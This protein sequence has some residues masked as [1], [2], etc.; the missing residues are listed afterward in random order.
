MLKLAVGQSAGTDGLKVTRAA[1]A[2]CLA[3]L[4]DTR[5]QAVLA[6]AAGEFDLAQV[7]AT[8]RAQWPGMVLVGCTSAGDFSSERGFDEDS[9]LLLCLGGDDLV[10][11]AGVVRELSLIAPQELEP[12]LRAALAQARLPAAPPESLCLLFPAGLSHGLEEVLATFQ[13]LLAPG[14]AVFGGLSGLPASSDPTGSKQLFGEEALRDGMPFLLL[15]G[16]SGPIDYGFSVSNSWTPVGARQTITSADGYVIHRIGERAALDFY[17][18]YLGSHTLPSPEFPLAVFQPDGENYALHVPLKADL[19]TG[20]ITYTSLIPEGSV[21]Q[22]TE[23]VRTR[24][25]DQLPS[26][27]AHANAQ[28]TTKPAVALAFSCMTRRQLLASQTSQEVQLLKQQLP[29]HVPLFG[30][31]ALGEIAPLVRKGPSLLHASSLVTLLLGSPEDVAA[32]PSSSSPLP[33]TAAPKEQPAVR[34]LFRATPSGYEELLSAAQAM[35][36]ELLA[37]RLARAE[38]ALQRMEAS[39]DNSSTLLRT[40]NREIDAA[41][42]L[43]EEQ[44]AVLS[45]LNAQL[46]DEKQKSEQLLLNILPSDVADELK[47]SGHV[48]PVYYDAA[49]V[50]FTDFTGFTHVAGRMTPAE[51]IAELDFY[52]SAFDRIMDRHGLEKLKTIGDAYMAAAG[53]PVPSTTHAIDAA[54][55]AW[56]ILQLMEQVM[57]DKQRQGQPH[58]NVRIGINTGPLMAGVIGRKKFAYDIWG[59]TVNI[60]SRLESTSHAGRINIGASTYA[61]IQ[62][63][64]RCEPRGK[65]TA[66]NAGEID[67][68]F[69]VE[70]L[71]ESGR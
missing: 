54:C 25:L 24:L 42:R 55:A 5:P 48:E 21:V 59:N 23:V 31:Y 15:S 62:H 8:V 4:G 19:R 35:E 68:Y 17:R 14:C 33:K 16:R 6:V 29:P 9:V 45:H 56:E 2:Q 27:V 67:M 43:I 39:R 69:I 50:L 41:R 66:K 28:L 10:I 61:Q 71:A 22:L 51:L 58:W 60:A 30:F 65:I 70:K 57:A 11:T 34:D 3:Q 38:L 26:A 1:L 20:S 52:F 7:G 64:F 44:N 46:A 49:S 63:L 32:R 53:V 13:A 37:R 12:S 18:H 40:I 47:R 36:P